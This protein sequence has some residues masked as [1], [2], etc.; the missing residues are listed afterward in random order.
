MSFSTFLSI[1]SWIITGAVAGYLSSAL[2]RARMGCLFKVAIG[3]IGALVGGFVAGL[4][5]VLSI[6]GTQGVG[7]FLSGIVHAIVGAVVVLLVLELIL[8]GR[9]LGVD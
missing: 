4:F 9:Q 8:P 5:P 3:V 6:F 1:A 2:L 7:G